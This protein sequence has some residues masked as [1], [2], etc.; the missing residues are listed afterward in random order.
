MAAG[1]R[2]VAMSPNLLSILTRSAA[3]GFTVVVMLALM[4]LIARD[5]L[6]GT[7]VTCPLHNWVISLETGLVQGPDEGA[8]RTFPVRVE[9]GRVLIARE[10]VMGRAA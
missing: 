8:V 2:Y 5:M 10:A 7:A 6:H 9:G 1:V 4:P 3:F